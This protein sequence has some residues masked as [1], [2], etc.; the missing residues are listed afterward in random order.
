MDHLI[1]V[2]HLNGVLVSTLTRLIQNLNVSF[3]PVRGALTLV[4]CN[5]ILAHHPA[6]LEL[7]DSTLPRNFLVENAIHVSIS[8]G[9]LPMS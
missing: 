4:Y 5:I 1:E 7:D 9:T 3:E 8:Y 2:L 6:V